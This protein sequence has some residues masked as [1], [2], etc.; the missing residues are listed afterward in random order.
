MDF[1]KDQKRTKKNL[2]VIQK[3]EQLRN[4]VT[5]NSFDITDRQLILNLALR[6]SGQ[7]RGTST[8]LVSSCGKLLEK[9][10]VSQ[11]LLKLLST[12]KMK[13]GHKELSEKDNPVLRLL[14]SLITYF[15]TGKGTLTSVNVT[16]VI[17]GMT[18][19]KEVI[20]MLQKCE[21]CIIYNNL[22]LLHAIWALRDAETSK[23][24][25]SEKHMKNLQ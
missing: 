25:P 7:Q 5:F 13:H 1:M 21:I 16:V 6:L 19:S 24:C 15:T 20:D 23:T 3:V 17:H 2:C 18:R 14:A 22:L 10:S 11:V 8:K 12:M 9:E 4:E